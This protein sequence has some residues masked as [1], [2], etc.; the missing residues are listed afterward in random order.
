MVKGRRGGA[1]GELGPGDGFEEVVILQGFVGG[2][3]LQAQVAAE[4]VGLVRRGGPH[5]GE[6]CVAAV[7]PPQLLR[8]TSREVCFNV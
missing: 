3:G 7:P 4:G 8:R 5:L 6:G 2:G 1:G